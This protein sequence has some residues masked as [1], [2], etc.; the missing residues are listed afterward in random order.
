MMCMQKDVLQ[1]A[2]VTIVNPKSIFTPMI[3]I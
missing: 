3:P 2:D 1:E